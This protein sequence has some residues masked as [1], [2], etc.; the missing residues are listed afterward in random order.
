MSP[1]SHCP[2]C[3]Y[4][5]PVVR[6]HSRSSAISFSEGSADPAAL[7]SPPSIPSWNLPPDL[8]W[9]GCFMQYGL[10]VESATGGA[11]PHHPPGDRHHRCP[12]L[13]HSRSVLLGWRG[14]G[15]GS[16]SL[17]RGAHHPGGFPGGGGGVRSPL[18]GGEGGNLAFQEGSHGRWGPEDDGNG[19]GL[20]R[21]PRGAPDPLPRRAPG[22][23]GFG[24]I[25]W[26]TGKLVPFGIFLAVGASVTYG[27]GERLISL[28]HHELPGAALGPP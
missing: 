5:D 11:V 2:G 16:G 1:P 28:V 8:I 19:G 23:R 14:P 17:R 22:I 27:W 12:V 15:I 24:P 10:S 13:H 26:K 21:G 7:P 20:P 6:Q 25:S 9:A 4:R 3:G 18:A